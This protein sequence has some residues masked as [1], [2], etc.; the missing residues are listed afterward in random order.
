MCFLSVGLSPSGKEVEGGGHFEG[1]AG[2][3]CVEAKSGLGVASERT[4]TDLWMR[5]ARQLPVDRPRSH[6]QLRLGHD[7]A[8]GG[9]PGFRKESGRIVIQTDGRC[10]FSPSRAAGRGILPPES[11]VSKLGVPEFPEHGTLEVPVESPA[12]PR[13]GKARCPI[14]LPAVLSCV[15][16]SSL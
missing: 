3:F 16:G 14:G 2:R 12:F 4:K 10:S 6:L 7:R 9:R 1:T 15:C 13:V 8:V 11:A 5:C